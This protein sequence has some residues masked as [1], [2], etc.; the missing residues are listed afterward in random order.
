M[1][2]NAKFKILEHNEK[3][4][5][6]KQ[7]GNETK[8]VSWKEHLQETIFERGCCLE[9]LVAPFKLSLKTLTLTLPKTLTF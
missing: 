8:L 3:Q 4:S 6:T 1:Q 2:E 7:N 5:N 9:T